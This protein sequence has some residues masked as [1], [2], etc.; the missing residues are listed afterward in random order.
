MT[1]VEAIFPFA[2]SVS[3]V[4]CFAFFAGVVFLSA[5]F[6]YYYLPETANRTATEIDELYETH[7]PEIPR[8]KG[9]Q[10]KNIKND[11]NKL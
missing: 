1:V 7:K 9:L 2:A 5:L 8:K 4:G 10:C 6:V 11:Y 3:L